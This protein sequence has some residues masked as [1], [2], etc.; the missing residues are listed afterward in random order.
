MLD[1]YY[2]YQ[3][4]CEDKQTEC[5]I[6]FLLEEQGIDV[7]RKMRVLPFAP[8][9]C[10]EAFVRKNIPEDIKRCRALNFRRVCLIVVIDADR[11][12]CEE[13]MRMIVNDLTQQNMRI[14][15]NDSLMLWIPRRNIESWIK[16]FREGI[17]DEEKDYDHFLRGNE[18]SCKLE[19]HQM[20]K[21]LN[22]NT[23]VKSQMSSLRVAQK[24]YN[25]VCEL[26]R[27][28]Q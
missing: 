17:T 10:A 2:S 24:E 14:E 4:R 23:L 21:A 8:G 28:T 25:K 5:Y 3:V 27:K 6:R 19:A 15:Q 1:K 20:S 22:D 11:Y 12:T 26:Q 9:D 13:R 16:H 18:A 7:K